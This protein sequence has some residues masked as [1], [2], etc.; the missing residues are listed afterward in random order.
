MNDK[1][2]FY[3]FLKHADIIVS[4]YKEL[5]KPPTIYG[6]PPRYRECFDVN[7]AKSQQEFAKMG[8]SAYHC[9]F[10][11]E[12]KE[13]YGVFAHIPL[14]K[15]TRWNLECIEKYKNQLVWLLLLEY[16]DFYFEEEHLKKYEQYIPWANISPD[17]P[18]H[19]PIFDNQTHFKS[20]T[21]LS[22][23]KNI[24][25]LSYDFIYSHISLIDILGLCTTGSFD[26][27]I[28]LVQLLLNHYNGNIISDYK[29]YEYNYKG[30]TFSYY[31]GLAKNERISIPYEVI[32][33]I[34]KDLQLPNWRLLVPLIIKEDLT[35]ENI[36]DLY[37]FDKQCFEAYLKLDFTQRRNL[38]SLINSND[39]VRNEIE[40]DTI[41][42]IWQGKYCYFDTGFQISE[43]HFK[44]L[45]YTYN[46]SKELIEQHID[47]WNHQSY[48]YHSG[49]QRTPDTNYHYHNRL[50]VWD[51][52]SNEKT[53]LLTYELY[54]YLMSIDVMVGGYYIIEDRDYL[55]TDIPN[56][57]TN[58]LKLF[59]FREIIND[60]EF[61]KIINDEAIID[62]LLTNASEKYDKK[63][64]T[65]IVIDKLIMKFFKDFS[66]EKFQELVTMH[67]NA[68]KEK[69]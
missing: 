53:L 10:E 1:D 3:L 5:T 35:P 64:E 25:K 61:N 17:E 55:A 62:F 51:V 36:L 18:T 19:L 8:S 34:A 20:G 68:N 14:Y 63:Y 67:K 49:M 33:Y 45:P 50:T 42:K 26:M 48:E 32:S 13:K 21:T 52:L 37:Y 7:F 15:Y 31:G 57:P 56:H 69:L 2:I 16:G 38:I 23:F 43:K 11:K 12:G 30:D 44:D 46:F 28:D 41:K 40:C 24:G 4:R 29:S 6:I 47:S 54:K 27:T 65:G 59:R 22:N 9:Y 39:K 58:A 66:F 60:E